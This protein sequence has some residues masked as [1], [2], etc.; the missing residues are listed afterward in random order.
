MLVNIHGNCS[1]AAGNPKLII[2]SRHDFLNLIKESFL[3][4]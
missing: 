2:V 4:S 1:I 3:N